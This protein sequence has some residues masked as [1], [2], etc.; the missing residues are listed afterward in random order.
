MTSLEINIG[1]SL[2]SSGFQQFQEIKYSPK[3]T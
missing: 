2:S 1:D 3:P